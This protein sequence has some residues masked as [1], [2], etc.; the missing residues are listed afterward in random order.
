MLEQETRAF[1]ARRKVHRFG[2]VAND[3][4]PLAPS[5]ASLFVYQ[6]RMGGVA[7]PYSRNAPSLLH[8]KRKLEIANRPLRFAVHKKP[9]FVSMLVESA[10]GLTELYRFEV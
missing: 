8:H 7:I 3:K 2:G 4:Y 6:E 5:L 9:D 10:F 1:S